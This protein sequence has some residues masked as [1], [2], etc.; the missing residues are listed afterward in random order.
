MLRGLVG[1]EAEEI[2]YLYGACDRERSWRQ[3]AETGQVFDRFT[4]RMGMP[5]VAQLRSL[6]ELSIVNELDVIEQNPTVAD[7]HGTY[8]RE[9]FASWASLAS[10]QVTRDAQRVLRP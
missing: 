5:D 7:R 8:L 6:V 1:T 9:L 4:G 3:L 2:V 10:E